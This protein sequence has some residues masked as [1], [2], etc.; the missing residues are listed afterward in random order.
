LALWKIINVDDAA[1][2]PKNRS[3]KFSS[4]LLHKDFW[5]GVSRYATTT[6]IVSLSPGHSDEIAR[7]CPWS[8]ITTGNHLDCAKRKIPKVAQ[9]TDAPLIFL[10]H[11]QAFRSPLR[12][13]LLHV[14]IFMNDGPNPLT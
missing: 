7:L 1:L 13:E 3:E 12:E 14:Q 11:V 6:L 10:I 2:I 9:R 4:I 8:P 5:E